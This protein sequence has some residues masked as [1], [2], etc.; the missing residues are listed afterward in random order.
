MFVDGVCVGV[1]VRGRGRWTGRVRGGWEGVGLGAGGGGAGEGTA[2][3]EGMERG[4]WVCLWP[5]DSAQAGQD[6]S[7]F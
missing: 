6:R 4:G 7:G 5:C 1:G 2:R 3:V